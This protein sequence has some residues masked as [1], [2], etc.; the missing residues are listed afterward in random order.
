MKDLTKGTTVLDRSDVENA[1]ARVAVAVFTYY[2]EKIIEEPGYVVDEDVDWAMEPLRSMDAGAL[3]QWR[4]R[5]NAVISDPTCD[6]R[7]FI[8]DFMALAED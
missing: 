2:P 8:A 4:G 7:A 3:D 5:V 6:R 1:F